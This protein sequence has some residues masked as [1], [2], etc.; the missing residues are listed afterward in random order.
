MNLLLIALDTTRADHLGCYGWQRVTS[1]HLDALAEK[2]VV[3]ENCIAPHIPT[4]PGYTIIFTGK[5]VMTHQVIA[6]GGQAELAEGCHTLPQV[7]VITH[8]PQLLSGFSDIECIR[9]TSKDEDGVHVHKP[10]DS[11]ALKTMLEPVIGETLGSLFESGELE[12]PPSP[13]GPKLQQ[14]ES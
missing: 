8:S 6:Q 2:G 5:D 10:A 12:I 4:H 11:K 1:P 3:V 7:I 14:A 13:S 9:V